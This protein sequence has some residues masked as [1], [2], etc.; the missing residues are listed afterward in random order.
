MSCIENQ[1]LTASLVA[2]S[3]LRWKFIDI[4][5]KIKKTPQWYARDFYEDELSME[6]MKSVLQWNATDA[7]KI[8]LL[9][10]FV[11]VFR[12]SDA[13]T[14]RANLL[15][16]LNK[17]DV[18]IDS[19]IAKQF[20][21]SYSSES[22][23][24]DIFAWAKRKLENSLIYDFIH[25]TLDINKLAK[26]LWL[27]LSKSTFENNKNVREA[28]IG[29]SDDD[30]KKILK[31]NNI[32]KELKEMW[33]SNSEAID[34]FLAY[35]NLFWWA[36]RKEEFLQAF[37]LV[38]W[39]KNVSKDS[40]L[41]AIESTNSISSLKQTYLTIAWNIKKATDEEQREIAEAIARKKKGLIVWDVTEDQELLA[42]IMPDMYDIS[43]SKIT[44]DQYLDAI[45]R[46]WDMSLESK[47]KVLR[48]T[49]VGMW[50]SWKLNDLEER[51]LQNLDNL[52]TDEKI[53]SLLWIQTAEEFNKEIDEII[54][55]INDGIKENS[56]IV[57]KEYKAEIE[58][59]VKKRDDLRKEARSVFKEDR[60]KSTRLSSEATAI[61]LEIKEKEKLSR[62]LQKFWLKDS[63]ELQKLND[64]WSLLGNLKEIK[65]GRSNILWDS[66][67]T[68]AIILSY[69][70][71]WKQWN[72][73]PLVTMKDVWFFNPE[74]GNWLLWLDKDMYDLYWESFKNNSISLWKTKSYNSIEELKTA[75]SKWEI[76]TIVVPS[77]DSLTTKVLKDLANLR[78]TEWYKFDF[79]QPN[80]NT[81]VWWFFMKDWELNFWSSDKEYMKEINEKMAESNIYNV[82]KTDSAK[83]IELANKV[84]EV[85]YWLNKWEVE[86]IAKELWLWDKYTIWDIEK[87]L[88]IYNKVNSSVREWYVDLDSLRL[89]LLDNPEKAK[90][91]FAKK[92]EQLAN[93]NWLA[94]TRDEINSKGIW[95]DDMV[96][97]YINANYWSKWTN[98]SQ[99]ELALLSKFFDIPKSK[100]ASILTKAD[101]D[102]IRYNA[103]VEMSKDYWL[104]LKPSYSEEFDRL[105][106]WARI[107]P[108]TRKQFAL[109]NQI[110]ESEV[111]KI[112]N[113]YYEDAKQSYNKP[114][115]SSVSWTSWKWIFFSKPVDTYK[116]LPPELIEE[117]IQ[118]I[119]KWASELEVIYTKLESTANKR[120]EEYR[121]EVK[122][123]VSKWEISAEKADEL[124]YKITKTL[125][126][127]DYEMNRAFI[128]WNKWKEAR[129]YI[130]SIPVI[131]DA[132]NIWEFDKLIDDLKLKY[133]W[134]I[135][136][137]L[138]EN[139]KI[140]EAIQADN[141]ITMKQ[142]DELLRDADYV[143]VK[144]WK[145][146]TKISKDEM[147]DVA[148]GDLPAGFEDIKRLKWSN[149]DMS[150]SDK[151]D[152]I[153][154]LKWLKNETLSRQWIIESIIRQYDPALARDLTAMK[155]QLV[156]VWD[157]SLYLPWYLL[158]NN[159][160]DWIWLTKTL[161]RDQDILIKEEILK[162]ISQKLTNWQWVTLDEIRL[163]TKE[164]IT[165][166][167][168]ITKD[169]LDS[170]ID[171]YTA[172]FV[173]YAKVPE[174]PEYMYKQLSKNINEDN[175]MSPE[176]RNILNSITFKDANG[177]NVV[178]S[179]LIKN[180][181]A[182]PDILYRWKDKVT[183]NYSDVWWKKLD[184]DEIENIKRWV[185][186]TMD[187]VEHWY[188]ISDSMEDNLYRNFR[189]NA[190]MAL[191]KTQR[192]KSL[193]N[194]VIKT[195]ETGKIASKELTHKQSEIDNLKSRAKYIFTRRESFDPEFIS[196]LSENYKKYM[197]MSSAEFA[198]VAWEKWEKFWQLSQQEKSAW[199]IANHYRTVRWYVK[200]ASTSVD[201][202]KA[203]EWWY[204]NLFDNLVEINE[205]TWKLWFKKWAEENLMNMQRAMNNWNIAYWLDAFKDL[206]MVYKTKKNITWVDE[207]WPMVWL[208]NFNRLF[209]TNYTL[210]DYRVI[211]WALGW[212]MLD[213]PELFRW[214]N[215][216]V[217]WM[218]LVWD[219]LTSPAMRFMSAMPWTLVS[220]MTSAWGYIK[221]LETYAKWNID[222][223]LNWA[224]E[225]MRNSG[226]L[227]SQAW[228]LYNTKIRDLIPW[229]EE[230]IDRLNPIRWLYA[231]MPRLL[232]DTSPSELLLQIT[233]NWQNVQDAIFSQ[234]LK[235]NA[236]WSALKSEWITSVEEF[237]KLLNNQNIPLEYR[238]RVYDRVISKTYQSFDWMLNYVWS[239][240]TKRLDD[241]WVTSRMSWWMSN[242][243][244]P[245]NFR[246]SL[247][248]NALKNSADNLKKVWEYWNRYWWSKEALEA[249]NKDPVLKN[250]IYSWF[251]DI[252]F[253]MK[254]ANMWTLW[255]TN[256]ENDID[257]TM[258]WD[259]LKTI[260]QNNQIMLTAWPMRVFKA[261][262]SEEEY[263][264][265]AFLSSYAQ[266]MF[267][268]FA[269][270]SN[271]IELLSYLRAWWEK[272]L[273][274]WMES[275]Y[276]KVST[277]ALRYWAWEVPWLA[278]S[279][280]KWIDPIFWWDNEFVDAYYWKSLAWLWTRLERLFDWKK[281][282]WE[283]EK[284]EFVKALMSI[285]KMWRTWN[286]AIDLATGKRKAPEIVEDL[287]GITDDALASIAFEEFN[288]TWIYELP[289]IPD[290]P[291]Y[292]QTREDINKY[293]KDKMILKETPWSSWWWEM[294]EWFYKT[295]KAA[296]TVWFWEDS[297]DIEERDWF[298]QLYEMMDRDG[299]LKELYNYQQNQPDKRKAEKDVSLAM[300]QYIEWLSD[301]DKWKLPWADAM[302]L[303]IWFTQ[304]YDDY[305]KN[306]SDEFK[307]NNKIYNKKWKK[308]N[309][310]ITD[311][312]RRS[313]DERFI[314]E[315][316]WEMQKRYMDSTLKWQE[317]SN[318]W[319][320]VAFYTYSKL[321]WDVPEDDIYFDVDKK[322]W[323]P[324][325]LKDKYKDAI[326]RLQ[327]VERWI[328]SW[329]TMQEM[330]ET[331]YWIF[332]MFPTRTK[333]W[334]KN[335]IDVEI[336]LKTAMYLDQ[337]AKDIWIPEDRRIQMSA[338]NMA[339]IW[340]KG[341]PLAAVREQL[342]DDFADAYANHLYKSYKESSQ[343]AIDSI[344]WWEKALWW[345][346]WWWSRLQN[347]AKNLSKI[348]EYVS[349][350]WW[351]VYKPFKLKS[352]VISPYS[353]TP[354]TVQQRA[355]S[356]PDLPVYNAK[357]KKLFA[358]VKAKKA[359]VPTAPTK[360]KALSKKQLQWI[361]K[362]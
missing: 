285:N 318:L 303:K 58:K 145:W 316:F 290:T 186:R 254:M 35:A 55:W 361:K 77:S 196:W 264:L 251:R 75:L 314:R 209:N 24:E 178:L 100:E 191:Q 261:W 217:K 72:N 344:E 19:N 114:E 242:V 63:K 275:N 146:I 327:Y 308:V 357:S 281:I 326:R 126:D 229:V 137:Q 158:R 174:I 198:S 312:E 138:K 9:D 22:S 343:L 259:I 214:N 239:D 7:S 41:K 204:S 247:W 175:L 8:W 218:R 167:F 350:N 352:S 202:N 1:V 65:T 345:G 150:N 161:D 141:S 260:S 57:T 333:Q 143:P 267:R 296:K 220:G 91:L 11:W 182:Y 288:R 130:T 268:Q 94:I 298:T 325:Q 197:N 109:K 211:M 163:F 330:W 266:N 40:I 205:N 356:R 349:Q 222:I 17:A 295:W 245:I 89:E 3:Q 87:R 258:V 226:I 346:K 149:F 132:Q 332:N 304:K 118:A 311:E 230:K 33:V 187:Q 317:F 243:I 171:S 282:D 18:G 219:I 15:K 270:W 96:S 14:K 284:W 277:A 324:Y 152:F 42:E 112:F 20:T 347:F 307:S 88:S 358:A 119:A 287:D 223:N 300:I 170:L 78:V 4:S 234:S 164:E 173:N 131:R 263:P 153:D 90:E 36:D 50:K 183:I 10:R 166:P 144:S 351:D 151:K 86:N 154:A 176:A 37:K 331:A 47:L 206:W 236:F 177:N 283:S 117:S 23:W 157:R 256:K 339:F 60:T 201:F 280:W 83:W 134:N 38:K 104:P 216:F 25:S 341:I 244:N 322:T 194:A 273:A 286:L 34:T 106:K 192:W 16:Q 46:V 310:S 165:T 246:W 162:K 338:A 227:S 240:L 329:K 262:L 98:P 228:D 208:E 64:I 2:D 293:I 44:P 54:D 195:L 74:A 294:V 323:E 139:K 159:S 225:F 13:N 278:V 319:S 248:L 232:S 241:W 48:N 95:I 101:I 337:A 238:R 133:G 302:Q 6:V 68:N 168:N 103:L 235:V 193:S 291:E 301:E 26:S 62:E 45:K 309:W 224:S 43:T 181:E 203:V 184:A 315:N 313:I 102:Q 92:V 85:K 28:L 210:E 116:S 105:D 12:W 200:D 30:L 120:I 128:T 61:E 207:F 111:E 140:I 99:W 49:I 125:K 188:F 172:E 80:S 297:Y 148:I 129:T 252:V 31:S 52:L 215:L 340:D 179:D 93:E 135:Q 160:S 213:N 51:V 299:V 29:L 108:W 253:S 348:K 21:Q 107:L 321:K 67:D 56:D 221:W 320:D 250:W 79:I 199:K 257:A 69:L 81:D 66:T 59:L 360:K 97:L 84:L 306:E 5:E 249:V 121:K 353:L 39:T 76:S 122:D 70:T 73:T 189:T 271:M 110:D 180:T 279:Q 274:V 335:V 123:L 136:D 27:E 276:D 265:A 124:K 328:K 233:D 237:A 354:E 362:K 272:W 342:W 169:E 359:S 334:D 289:Y 305:F 113:K 255:E 82:L 115:K 147:I 269:A 336:M 71:N 190:L 53:E 185:T 212:D 155:N 142:V 231:D 292:N 355:L 156:Q 32:Y 127:I